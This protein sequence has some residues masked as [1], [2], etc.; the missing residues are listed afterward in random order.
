MMTAYNFI[1]QGVKLNVNL[2]WQ[3]FEIVDLT[4]Y[5]EKQWDKTQLLIYIIL[6]NLRGILRHY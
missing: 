3:L 5:S 2:F 6:L 1:T 4:T